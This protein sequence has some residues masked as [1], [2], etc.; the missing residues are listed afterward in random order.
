VFM[1]C[2]QRMP[3]ALFIRVNALFIFFHKGAAPLRFFRTGRN[4]TAGHYA[5]RGPE[6]PSF[7]TNPL[8]I[9]GLSVCI[10]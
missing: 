7:R 9:Q 1:Q 6:H 8:P 5:A 4:I 2:A 10:T 3:P